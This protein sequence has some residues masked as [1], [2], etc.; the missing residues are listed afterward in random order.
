ML[1]NGDKF[2]CSYRAEKHQEILKKYTKSL[3]YNATVLG[4]Q[5]S[6][7]LKKDLFCNQAIIPIFMCL[8][9]IADSHSSSDLIVGM[10]ALLPP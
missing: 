9:L 10:D 2:L 6:P 1:K 7:L 4:E 8:F 3:S 5:F